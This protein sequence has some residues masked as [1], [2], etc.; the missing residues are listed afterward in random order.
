MGDVITSGRFP[1]PRTKR[2]SARWRARF[3]RRGPI[4]T[5]AD[6]L[7]GGHDGVVRSM[8]REE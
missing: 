7:P 5:L 2:D 8:R 3:A 4:A 1:K 6:K